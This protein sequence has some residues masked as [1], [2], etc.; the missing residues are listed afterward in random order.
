MPWS[1]P[2]YEP[3][4]RPR[5]MVGAAMVILVALAALWWLLRR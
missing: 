4:I 2:D 3:P 1:S 5:D